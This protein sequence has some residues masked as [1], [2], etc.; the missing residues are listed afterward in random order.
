MDEIEIR[1]THN[2]AKAL[3][4]LKAAYKQ[5]VEASRDM[6][7]YDISEAYPFY[8]LDFEAIEPAVLQWCTVHA[9]RLLKRLPYQVESPIPKKEVPN[10]ND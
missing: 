9:T 4:T 5:L 2:L 6:P 3:L 8:L 7:D 1:N 10:G